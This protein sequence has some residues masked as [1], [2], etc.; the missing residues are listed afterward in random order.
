[1]SDITSKK[2]TTKKSAKDNRTVGDS[3][4]DRNIGFMWEHKILACKDETPIDC[5]SNL[6]YKYEIYL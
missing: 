5:T 4:S 6:I 3:K 2:N 1:M